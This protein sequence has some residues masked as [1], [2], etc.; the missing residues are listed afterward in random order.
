MEPTRAIVGSWTEFV[1]ADQLNSQFDDI[2]IAQK[3]EEEDKVEPLKL[4]ID[5]INNNGVSRLKFSQPT[6]LPKFLNYQKDS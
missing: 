4:I 2:E 5:E 6:I 3:V 1:S